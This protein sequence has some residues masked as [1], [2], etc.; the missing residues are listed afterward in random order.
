MKIALYLKHGF[1]QGLES[2][3]LKPRLSTHD[4]VDWYAGEAAP[5]DDF[6]VMIVADSLD[7]ATIATQRNLFFVQTASAGYEGIDIDAATAAGIWVAFAPAQDTGNAVSVA[8]LGVML[9]IGASR[10]LNRALA[11]VRDHELT[12][13]H[14]ATALFGK[15]AC[16]V[17]LG[18]VGRALA[19]RLAPFGMVVRG[20][21]A[22]PENAP[23][24]VDAYPAGSLMEAVRDADYVIVCAPGSKQNEHLIDA[25]VLAGM[26]DG[27]I[28]V[29]VARGTLIDEAAL[30]DALQS[31]HIAAVGLDVL[32]VEPAARDN[33][34]LPYPQALIT[35]HIAG[36]TDVMLAGTIDYLVRVIDDLGTSKKPP[37]VLNTPALRLPVHGHRA[38]AALTDAATIFRSR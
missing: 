13:N 6:D 15:I 8:E 35:P 24:G 29:N 10:R 34:L 22:H 21:D 36:S 30:A 2:T 38:R 5:A 33:P 9:M 25:R 19:E 4:V 20:T 18:A 26:K 11:S 27:A 16:I 37:S 1:L 28:V 12:P 32:R 7:R 14:L 17:G 3:Q 23:P 31:G